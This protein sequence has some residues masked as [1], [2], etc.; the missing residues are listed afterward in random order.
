MN[1]PQCK[2]IAKEIKNNDHLYILG[3]G[4][5]DPIAKE[6]ALKIKEVSYMHAEGFAAGALKHGTFALIEEGTPV[7]LL[8]MNDEYTD[9]MVNVFEQLHCRGAKTIVITS[10]PNLI[11]SNK[12]PDHIIKIQDAGMMTALL[13]AVPLQLLAFHLSL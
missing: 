11:K 8:I 10:D 7:V 2:K 1:T 5:G 3:R 4:L 6:G 12:V 9:L 13:A